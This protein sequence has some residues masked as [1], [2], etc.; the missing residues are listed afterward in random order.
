MMCQARRPLNVVSFSGSVSAETNYICDGIDYDDVQ[1]NYRMNVDA[2][3]RLFFRE[4]C[5]PHTRQKKQKVTLEYRNRTS[6]H[7][8]TC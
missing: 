5:I 7:L 1:M 3:D 8:I 6:D 2:Q 4:L